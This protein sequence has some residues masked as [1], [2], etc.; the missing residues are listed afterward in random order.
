MSGTLMLYYSFSGNTAFVADRMKELIP[1]L[2]VERLI[3]ENEPP[4]KGFARYLLGGA[5]AI[6]RLD[7]ALFP[8]FHDPN[9]FEKVILAFPLWAGTYPPAVA[10]LIKK[11]PFQ[12]K[13]LYIIACSSSGRAAKAIDA[14]AEALSANELRG[15]L[16]LTDPLS[17]RISSIVKIASFARF[18]E[19]DE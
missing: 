13:K 11:A 9:T 16:S 5:G 10:A 2:T 4:K 7:P 19:E 18:T 8:V 3:A 12:G 6:F 17:D 14:V 1:E 15:S